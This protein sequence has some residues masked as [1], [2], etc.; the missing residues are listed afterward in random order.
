MTDTLI[1]LL[2]S[3]R[4]EDRDLAIE[5][6]HNP[7]L[8]EKF[9]GSFPRFEV[10]LW[11][12]VFVEGGFVVIGQRF[13]WEKPSWIL[14]RPKIMIPRHGHQV[15]INSF[16]KLFREKTH[17]NPKSFMDRLSEHS[18]QYN[19]AWMG[20]QTAIAKAEKKQRDHGFGQTEREG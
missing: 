4:K 19:M 18:Y 16:W 11:N 2:S 8:F 15:S 20:V 1:T 5:L 17:D 12:E 7:E 13:R 10:G 14:T 6:L 9:W 3:A